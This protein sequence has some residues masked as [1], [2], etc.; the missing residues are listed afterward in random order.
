MSAKSPNNQNGK[1]S[2]YRPVNT[3]VFNQNFDIIFRKN[4]KNAKKENKH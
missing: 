1:G 3:K 2:K 4:N